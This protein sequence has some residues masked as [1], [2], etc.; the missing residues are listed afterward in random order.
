MGSAT[1]TYFSTKEQMFT[2]VLLLQTSRVYSA[3]PIHTTM[4]N[5]NTPQSRFSF[6]AFFCDVICRQLGW[7]SVPIEFCWLF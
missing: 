1:E 3:Y 7:N 5:Q 6:I 4:F 2:E